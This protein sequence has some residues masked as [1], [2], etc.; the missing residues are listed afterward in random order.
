[1]SRAIAVF[2]GQF[3]R[4]AVYQ[5]NRP[6]NIHA[7]REGHLIFHLGGTDGHV[8]VGGVR[9]PANAESAIA[10]SPWEPHNF[11]PHDFEQGSLFL[12]FYV[13]PDWFAR[14]GGSGK[15]LVRRNGPPSRRRV[16]S[17]DS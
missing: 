12:V 10:V 4:A 9:H 8:D 3:G 2:H 7:H 13:N 6:F 17:A 11:V 16:R 15:T 5:L 14:A 1:M